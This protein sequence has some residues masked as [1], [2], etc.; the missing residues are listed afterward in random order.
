MHIVKI[1]VVVCS[2]YHGESGWKEIHKLLVSRLIALSIQTT[3]C[4][5]KIN[6]HFPDLIIRATVNTDQTY[7]DA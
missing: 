7:L 4:E 5:E 3:N 6:V 1:V 2:G